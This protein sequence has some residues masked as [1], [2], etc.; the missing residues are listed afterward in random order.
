MFDRKREVID[1]QLNWKVKGH[2]TRDDEILRVACVKRQLTL[3]RKT[4]TVQKPQV[5]PLKLNSE[6]LVYARD[7]GVF[8]A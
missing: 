2:I 7:L 4:Q 1:I 6:A 5:W 8:A 3:P